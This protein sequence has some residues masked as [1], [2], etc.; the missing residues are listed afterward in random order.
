MAMST[1]AYEQKRGQRASA[2][3]RMPTAAQKL[4]KEE[5]QDGDSYHEHEY[6]PKQTA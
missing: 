1:L 4:G 3:Q 6:A 5:Q 2:A